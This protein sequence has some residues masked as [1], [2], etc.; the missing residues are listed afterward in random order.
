MIPKIIHYIWF[1]GNPLPDDALRCIESWKK[2]CPDYEV[3]EWNETNFDI[4][5]CPYVKEAYEAKKWAFVSDY[6]RLFVLVN[7]GGIYMDTD[8]ELV[9]PLDSFLDLHAFSGFESETAVPTGIMAC[10]KGTPFFLNL[11]DEYK[12]LH[13]ID[14][15]GDF[16]LTT[17]VTRITNQ[18]VKSGLIL[19]N[20]K[21]TIDGFT[22]FPKDF[23]CPLSS[24]TG[25]LE[26]TEN[27]HAI[28]WFAGSWKTAK[29]KAVHE[30]AKQIIKKY[31]EPIG[32]AIANVYELT[33]KS[34]DTFC[35]GGV[36]SLFNRI[37]R[38]VEKKKH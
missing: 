12:D 1:G 25:V 21:Q 20:T 32:R 15:N 2:Y 19:N 36:K 18:A 14:K 5:C 10:E 16:D 28:H 29:E 4:N 6:T 33:F 22:L 8:V 17:N 30:K 31:P 7:Y 11:L 37:K 23:F 13:F 34:V 24:V 3:K 26:R 27:T 35:H 9:K 38:Y